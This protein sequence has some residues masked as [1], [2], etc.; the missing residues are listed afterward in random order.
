[1]SNCD[2]D[3]SIAGKDVVKLMDVGQS[4]VCPTS[5]KQRGTQSCA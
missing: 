4:E 3:R 2:R 1:M 5:Q